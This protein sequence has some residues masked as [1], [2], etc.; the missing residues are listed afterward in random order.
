MHGAR[1]IVVTALRYPPGPPPDP[2][3]PEK[4]T[5]RIAAYARG[6]DYHAQMAERLEALGARIALSMGGRF[7]SHVDAGPLVEKEL[8]RRAGLGWY[9]RNTNV[10][11]KGFGSYF[12]LGCLL[13]DLDLEPD[14]PFADEHCGDCRACIPACPTGALD[15]GP[16]IDAR[17]CVSYLTIELR[18]PLPTSLRPLLANWVF[19]CDDCQSVCPWNTAVPEAR[20]DFL[21]PSLPRLLDMTDAEF[22]EIYGE[23]AVSRVRRRGLARNAALA[24]G[25]SHNRDALEPLAKALRE[26]PELTVRAAAAWAVGRLGGDGARRALEK[27]DC[28]RESAPVAAEVRAAL[29]RLRQGG[30]TLSSAT[31]GGV[32]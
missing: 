17:R 23:T 15:S 25:N 13:T 14:A 7:E 21:T 29:A 2:L 18:G 20:D 31:A 10:L 6:R 22:D 5:G 11:T 9:G 12:L 27:V 4:L 32:R 19:G 30:D 26:D 3:W 1:S 24:L 16:T 8:A 28:G